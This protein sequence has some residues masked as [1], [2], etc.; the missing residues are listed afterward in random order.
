[1]GRADTDDTGAD[2]YDLHEK[3]AY[4]GA[5]LQLKEPDGSWANTELLGGTL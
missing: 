1:M 3:A 5:S 4:F 2:Y